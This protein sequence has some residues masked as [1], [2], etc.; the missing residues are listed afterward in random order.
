MSDETESARMVMLATGKPQSDLATAERHWTTDELMSDFTVQGFLSP[1]VV[2]TRKADGVKGTMM[3]THS[4][5]K[6]FNFQPD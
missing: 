2:V 1:F 3:F 5:R 6:Y 4:P